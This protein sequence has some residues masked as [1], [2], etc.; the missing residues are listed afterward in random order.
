[1][2]CSKNTKNI[3]R[4]TEC[5]CVLDFRAYT[6]FPVCEIEQTGN[7]PEPM[8]NAKSKIGLHGVCPGCGATYKG[9]VP[10]V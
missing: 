6:E 10:M 2:S 9:E 8:N 4:C 5:G 1:M 3:L 7:I